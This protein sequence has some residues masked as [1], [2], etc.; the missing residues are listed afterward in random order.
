M[1]IR[2]ARTVL[3]FLSIAVL[4]SL[5]SRATVAA[6]DLGYRS[7]DEPMPPPAARDLPGLSPQQITDAQLL[8][9]VLIGPK[10]LAVVPLNPEFRWQEVPGATG[11]AISIYDS[12][13]GINV[14]FHGFEASTICAD[15][16]CKMT[17][18]ESE[19]T[20]KSNH[21]HAW[22]AAAL[23]GEWSPWSAGE[24]FL[25]SKIPEKPAILSP[26]GDFVPK[27]NSLNPTYQWS[28]DG[29]AV[30]YSLVVYNTTT[31]A[32]Q[33]A[34]DFNLLTDPWICQGNMCSVTLDSPMAVLTNG[35]RYVAYVAGVSFAGAGP[36]SDGLPFN[37]FIRPSVPV[38]LAPTGLQPNLPT[39]LWS[40][41]QGATDY[42]IQILD[43][44]GQSAFNQRV[45]ADTACATP[46][47]QFTLSTPLPQGMYYTYIASGN[48]AG[49]SE[50]FSD[51][52]TFTVGASQ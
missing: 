15:G 18:A 27:T 6:T 16:I 20:L 12:E 46:P 4:V 38:I 19:T 28:F 26:W 36:W 45:S 14:Y 37:I 22:Y 33:V 41:V 47:C 9:P 44:N 3:I 32:V 30:L 11:Y 35:E 21:V 52:S 23:L 17:P 51:V 48:V 7:G 24:L 40:K 50:T 1:A 39:I 43:A 34:A 29:G 5:Q 31:G 25:A 49:I 2:A 42:Y 13:T 10:N 8:P